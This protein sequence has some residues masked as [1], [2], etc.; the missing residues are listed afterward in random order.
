MQKSS[1]IGISKDPNVGSYNVDH[2]EMNNNLKYY[3]HDTDDTWLGTGIW[4][5]H[6]GNRN[7][8]DN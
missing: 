7:I 8:P 1:Q 6:I 4:D 5:V 3:K 2:I